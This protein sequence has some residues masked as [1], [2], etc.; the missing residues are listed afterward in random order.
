MDFENVLVGEARPSDPSVLDAA[1]KLREESDVPPGMRI[2]MQQ[3]A[4]QQE[5]V[6]RIRNTS[7]RGITEKV[8]AQAGL[9]ADRKIRI[10][11]ALPKRN[12]LP[13][14]PGIGAA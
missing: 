4:L 8:P 11:R 12:E 10:R 6:G 2:G 13:R 3:V 9:A 14:I 7:E 1:L 5:P